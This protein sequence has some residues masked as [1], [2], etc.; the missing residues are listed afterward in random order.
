MEKKSNVRN[1]NR[2]VQRMARE[3]EERSKREQGKREQKTQQRITF[4]NRSSIQ[5]LF[6]SINI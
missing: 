1:R 3:N 5:I 2:S 4:V 6:N